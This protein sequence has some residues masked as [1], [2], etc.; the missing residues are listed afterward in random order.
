MTTNTP[1]LPPSTQNLALAIR[2]PVASDD[3][4]SEDLWAPTSTTGLGTSPSMKD[5]AAAVYPMVSVPWGMII[6]SAPAF[7]SSDTASASFCQ[8]ST[9]MF[10]ENIEKST[11]ASMLATP[12]S[13]GTAFT[14][15][16]VDKAGWT[17]PVL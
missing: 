12:L 4:R 1:A 13:S 8:C 17:A 6:P 14:S 9:F 5:R 15:S 10:S 11:L 2:L 3:G 7:I 16:D